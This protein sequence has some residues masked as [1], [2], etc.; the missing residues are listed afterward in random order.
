VTI[1]DD[2]RSLLL[3][4]ATVVTRW[5]EEGAIEGGVG[6]LREVPVLKYS[7]FWSFLDKIRENAIDACISRKEL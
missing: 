4:I 2:E 5:L 7:A 6:G 1:L 3:P